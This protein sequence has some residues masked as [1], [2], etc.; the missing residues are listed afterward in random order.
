M[1]KTR[2]SFL[3][4]PPEQPLP[5][6]QA[7]LRQARFRLKED[8]PV[9]IAGALA[10]LTD[11]QIWWRPNEAS[12]SIGNLILHLCGNIRQWMIAGVGGATDQRD[13]DSEFAE[14]RHSTPDL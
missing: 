7:F 11:A 3:L 9:K 8:Y 5:A 14:R 6:S 4:E 12:N 10:E 1:K 13:R 2:S